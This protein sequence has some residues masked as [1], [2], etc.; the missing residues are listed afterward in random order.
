[1]PQAGQRVGEYILI[2]PIGQG[3]FGSVWL[4]RHHAWRD[5]LAAVKLPTDTAYVRALQREGLTVRRV[6]H[7]NIVRALAFDAFSEPPYLVLE[8]VK[9]KNLRQLLRERG[10]FSSE[11]V[12]AILA[13]VLQG[14]RA[15]HDAGIVHRDLK[16]EN[17][18]VH[19]DALSQGFATTGTVKVTD[20]GL[21][22]AATLS[23]ASIALSMERSL[24][25]AGGLAGTLEYMSPEQRAGEKLDGRSDLYAVGVMLFELLTGAKPVGGARPSDSG[26]GESW[27][28]LYLR[29][30]APLH[31]RFASAND[32]SESLSV[33]LAPQSTS[34]EPPLALTH[35]RFDDRG[36]FG[37]SLALAL[38]PTST[39]PMHPTGTPVSL[40]PVSVQ[41]GSRRRIM[42]L[43]AVPVVIAFVLAGWAWY[44]NTGPSLLHT[45][46]G[47]TERVT[48][49]SFSPD[50]R[51]V[52]TVSWDRTARVWDAETGRLLQTLAGYTGEVS[53]AFSPD[54]RRV[55]TGS[56][57]TI[58]RLWDAET[59]RLLH[60]LVIYGTGRVL[61]ASF[62]PD[63]R[64]IVTVGL[65]DDTARLWDAETGTLLHTLKG[66]A[67]AVF[68]ASFSPDGRQVVTGSGD[69]TAR[70]W[71]IQTGRLL[72]ALEG[73]TSLVNCSSFSPD[74]RQVVTGSA[75]K[76]A[77]LWDAET[78]RLRHTL[79]GHTGRVSSASFS[80][81]G[82]RVL[83]GS[84][85]KTV[86]LWDVE[87]GRLL[88]TV[89]VD[90]DSIY[91]ASFS[92]RG[93]R[94]VTGSDDTT[95]RVWDVETGREIARMEA[96]QQVACAAFSPDGR[97][98]V[99]G[100]GD[101]DPAKKRGEAQ[102]WQLAD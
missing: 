24:T 84:S 58:G 51:R 20:F 87:T 95:A 17:V 29:A 48:H 4:A 97:Q 71:D 64:K 21:G 27:D 19:E 38:T 102:V 54:G 45:L 42:R 67:H 75:D 10:K 7:A 78:G 65:L 36:D 59:G 91:A 79:E 13:Q 61:D 16:P 85:D 40:N 90:T 2:E 57:D 26:Y 33:A 70:L 18:L 1:M 100:V 77:R 41:T 73:H 11:E 8:Y 62:S 99:L 89:G 66:H 55:V 72:H 76:T 69:Q 12:R 22:T 31:A 23:P 60:M 44:A 82:R 46:E 86:R 49:A 94:V 52:L 63:G 32:F 83:T 43:V 93:T 5:D 9:G 15:A 35:A 30:C 80:P 14:L 53:A 101:K 56:A 34:P 98:I 3:A 88:H 47:H 92:P 96:G 25:N 81:D 50:G 28:G 6:Q 39:T 37:K 74:G 68:D